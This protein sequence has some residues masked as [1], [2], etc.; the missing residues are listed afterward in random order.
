MA[1]IHNLLD[2]ILTIFLYKLF[3]NNLKYDFAIT[4]Y[5]GNV[6]KILKN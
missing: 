2:Q 4:I 6:F 1:I 3:L 5:F